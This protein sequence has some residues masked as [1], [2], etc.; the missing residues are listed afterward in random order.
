MGDM[1]EMKARF[2]HK[3]VFWAGINTQRVLPFGSVDDV[4]AEVK[5]RIRE[6][7]PGGGFVV[8]SVHAIQPDVPPENIVATAEATRKCGT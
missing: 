5:L 7:G 4:D 6:M 3:I 8:A 2:G 1:T